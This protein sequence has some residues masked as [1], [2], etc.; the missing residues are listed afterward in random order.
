MS[1]PRT[2]ASRA[3]RAGDLA[4]LPRRD[5][6]LNAAGAPTSWAGPTPSR[7]TPASSAT[8]RTST[9]SAGATTRSAILAVLATHV[10]CRTEMTFPHW[11]GKA[12][13]PGTGG[14]HRRHLQLGQRHRG[15]GRRAGSR[16]AVEAEVLGI[17][18]AAVPRGG[19]HL[20]QGVHHGAR[21]LRRQRRRAPPARPRPTTLDWN[22][23]LRRFEPHWRVLLSHLVLFG[24]IYPGASAATVPALGDGRADAPAAGRGGRAAARDRASARARCSRARST[25]WTSSSGDTRTRAWSRAIQMTPARHR[26]LDAGHR[27]P[28]PAPEDHR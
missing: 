22:R 3:P 7:A 20:V 2:A 14:L 28:E 8:P 18:V 24:F 1:A 19:D 17:P 5:A 15:G 21:A 4:V 27:R 6:A 26:A 11:L 10:G 12:Y 9:S 13:N 23:V 25:S 16:T